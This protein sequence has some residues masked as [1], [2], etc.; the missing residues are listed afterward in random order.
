MSKYT[1]PIPAGPHDPGTTDPSPFGASDA[2][3]G[4]TKEKLRV[5]AGRAN[6]RL[7][8]LTWPEIAVA[9]LA[10]FA[11]GY[12]LA[13]PRRHQRLRDIV[14]D[15]LRPWA[16]RNL[17]E[18]YDQVRGSRPVSAVADRLSKLRAS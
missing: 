6:E 4:G 10:G 11:L 15:S 16:S 17:H 14:D 3:E 1:P 12:L 7:H 5:A 8:K 18:A 9:G 2:R 13:A